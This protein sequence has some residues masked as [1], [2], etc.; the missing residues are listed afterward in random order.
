[1]LNVLF[2]QYVFLPTEQAGAYLKIY[3]FM[4]YLTYIGPSLFG[5]KEN[6]IFEETVIH[7]L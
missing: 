4:Y 2:V 5:W 1:M 6:I 3:F 7:K